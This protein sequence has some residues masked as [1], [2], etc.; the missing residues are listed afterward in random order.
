MVVKCHGD[1]TKSIVYIYEMFTR[2]RNT[3]SVYIFVL[4]LPVVCGG[5]FFDDL[6][7]RKVF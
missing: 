5:I 6:I 2:C 3:L 7:H 4:S 1:Q